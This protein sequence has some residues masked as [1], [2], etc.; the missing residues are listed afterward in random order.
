MCLKKG[1][2]IQHPTFCGQDFL[3][4]QVHVSYTPSHKKEVLINSYG[5]WDARGFAGKNQNN[6]PSAGDALDDID[7]TYC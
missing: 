3:D 5:A 6:D 2:S 1:S 4:I 7:A